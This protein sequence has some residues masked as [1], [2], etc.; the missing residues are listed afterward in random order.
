MNAKKTTKPPAAAAAAAFDLAH[1]DAFTIAAYGTTAFRSA[2]PK[3]AAFDID[4]TLIRPKGKTVFP[5]SL[6][7]W[8]WIC[9][10]VKPGLRKAV[11]DDGFDIVFITNQKKMSSDD[12]KAKAAMLYAD[13]QVPFVLVA[14]HADDYYRKPHTGLWKVVVEQ[15]AHGCVDVKHSFFVGDMDTDAAFAHNVGLEFKP[16]A[17]YWN[18]VGAAAGKPIPEYQ[19]PLDGVVVVGEKDYARP[20]GGGKHL[21]VTV[22]PAASG[23]S[24]IAARLAAAGGGYVVINQD[25]LKTPAKQKASFVKAVAAG[26]SIIVDNTNPLPATRAQWIEAAKAAGYFATIVFIDVPKKAA[27]YL[28]EYRYEVSGGQ[29]SHVPAVAYNVYYSKL[30]RPEP[31]E[32]DE[33]VTETQILVKDEAARNKLTE[34]HFVV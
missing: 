12:V 5:K 1:N 29:T 17:A 22:G 28:N 9:E 26:Q 13:L 27:Q 14:G 31:S 10:A 18:L 7:D 33:V 30:V 21:I 24:L 8:Q 32:A 2:C 20:R 25:T 15:L 6:D 34:M 16:A 19:H 23:K 3:L 11:A 4:G